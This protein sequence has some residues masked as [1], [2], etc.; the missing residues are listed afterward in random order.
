AQIPSRILRGKR[1]SILGYANRQVPRPI[2]KRAYEILL[3]HAAAGDIIASYELLPFDQVS[4]VWS[5]QQRGVR[6]RL[7]LAWRHDS[8]N[9]A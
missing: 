8:H 5:W 2:R 9:S 4:D 3:S 7:V 6:T 1:L